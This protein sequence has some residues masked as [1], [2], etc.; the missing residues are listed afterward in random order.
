MDLF[1]RK[2]RYIDIIRYDN[3]FYI[4]QGFQRF[5]QHL[6]GIVG[7]KKERDNHQVI[8]EEKVGDN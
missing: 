3:Q 7:R 6:N 5:D 4:F 2:G 1:A 8:Y